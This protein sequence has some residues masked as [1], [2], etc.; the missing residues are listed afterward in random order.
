MSPYAAQ[1]A[2]FPSVRPEPAPSLDAA[3]QRGHRGRAQDRRADRHAPPPAPA[4]VPRP[5]PGAFAAQQVR[6]AHPHLT[7]QGGRAALSGRTRQEDRTVY[8]ARASF[9]GRAP[10]AERRANGGRAPHGRATGPV[11]GSVPSTGVTAAEG[12][13]RGGPEAVASQVPPTPAG[14]EGDG[15]TFGGRGATSRRRHAAPLWPEGDG[16]AFGGRGATSRRPYATP[17]LPEGDGPTFGERTGRGRTTAPRPVGCWSQG[18][19]SGS[20]TDSTASGSTA[21]GAS[22]GDGRRADNAHGGAAFAHGAGRQAIGERGRGSRTVDA[23]VDASSFVPPAGVGDDVDAGAR[24]LQALQLHPW[25]RESCRG[26]HS[27][28]RWGGGSRGFAQ[29]REESLQPA[30]NYGS[31]QRPTF[32]P[33]RRPSADAPMPTASLPIAIGAPKAQAPWQS[34]ASSPGSW[35]SAASSPRQGTRTA[36]P[37]DPWAAGLQFDD[38]ESPTRSPSPNTRRRFSTST[39]YEGSVGS[40]LTTIAR[41]APG[42]TWMGHVESSLQAELGTAARARPANR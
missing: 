31:G 10:F 32:A 4:A 21:A 3:D 20:V 25:S 16:P 34:P 19:R 42:P 5:I 6:V 38:L 33:Y 29:A 2:F 35:R 18:P 9:D 40:Y 22:V 39:P 26:A 14:S 36:T 41:R 7:S 37:E 8:T 23:D 12:A 24:A 11:R 27:P 1:P 13:W 30:R 28:L 17:T 15:P